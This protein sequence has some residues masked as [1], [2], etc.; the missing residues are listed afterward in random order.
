MFFLGVETSCDET[1]A[2]IVN[3][4]GKVFSSV[5]ASQL[6]LHAP[7]GGVVPELA[8]RQ[9]LRDLPRVTAEA[10]QQAGIGWDRLDGVAATHGP[11]LMGALLTGLTWAKA[12]A[13]ARSLAFVG[14][15]HLEGHLLA[16]ELNQ[17]RLARPFV[18][19]I[20]S[21][22]HTSLYRVEEG[23]PAV[24]HLLARTRDD[25]VGEA[26]DKVAKLLGLPYP[27]GPAIEK[28]A[29]SWHSSSERASRMKFTAA[30]MKDGSLEF[31]YSG[32]KTAV[33]NV[34]A[35]AREKGEPVEIAEVADAFQKTIVRDLVTKSLAIVRSE[36]VGALALTGG[37]AANRSLRET[38]RL[39]CEKAGLDF[40]CPPIPWCTDNAAM[41]AVAGA[42]R[43]LAG[44]RS[45]WDLA[46]EPNLELK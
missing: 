6:D 36:G 28:A 37:V 26:F 45:G 41:I 5:V 43:L 40:Y 19:L 27:G 9:H 15:N 34:L 30:R 33:R 18:G 20:A 24:Y 22:G 13:Y 44:Q 23:R 31:S 14:V 11:G 10:F 32:L 8:S 25:A 12:A 7:F 46:A 38:F 29:A 3:E 2:A 39:E 16:V 35:T 17:P 21:G 4:D 42:R 1:A